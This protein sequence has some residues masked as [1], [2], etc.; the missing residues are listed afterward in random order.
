V[1]FT[2]D[3]AVKGPVTRYE[4]D[5]GTYETIPQ[6]SGIYR[7]IWEHLPNINQIL[8]WLKICWQYI[9]WEET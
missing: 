8:Q 5:N 4:N 2:D 3:V 1:P 9:F 6:N 7:S